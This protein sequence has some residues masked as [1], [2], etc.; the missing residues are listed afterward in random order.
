MS[1]LRWNSAPREVW[2]KEWV[3]D[4]QA[5]GGGEPVL[6][7]L[8]N[9]VYKTALGSSSI[10]KDENGQITFRYR[11]SDTGKN[12]LLSL[13]AS[14]FIRRF[15]QHVLPGGFQRVRYFGWLA[16]AARKRF[17]RIRALLDW[18]EPEKKPETAPPPP[19]ICKVCGTEMILMEELPRA[20]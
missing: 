15:L 8:A 20:P 11:R 4:C 19:P 14:E 3:V 1:K 18:K 17:A 10:L 12:D 16:P 9:Y 6:V 2:K 5:V 13:N 7:Y